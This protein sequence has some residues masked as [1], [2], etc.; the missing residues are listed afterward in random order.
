MMLL[1]NL[2]F[3]TPWYCDNNIHNAHIDFQTFHNEFGWLFFQILPS[4]NFFP[5]PY[6]SLTLIIQGT[7]G[8]RSYVHIF[9]YFACLCLQYPFATSLLLKFC[10]FFNS[11]SKYQ[12][13]RHLLPQ[14]ISYSFSLPCRILLV[15]KTSDLISSSRKPSLT[16]ALL[17]LPL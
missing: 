8:I 10:P 11:W 4:I 16:Y 12:I 1:S 6:A 17:P 5:V 14:L 3:I 15:H 9:I 7:Q 13:H 2:N